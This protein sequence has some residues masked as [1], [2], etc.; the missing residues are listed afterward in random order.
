M[1]P[2]IPIDVVI[3]LS[4]S[5]KKITYVHVIMETKVESISDL[6]SINLEAN[7]LKA[8]ATDGAIM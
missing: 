4:K 6:R 2:I 7:M 8:S 1:Y 3:V 5:K